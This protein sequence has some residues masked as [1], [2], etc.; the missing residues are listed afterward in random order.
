MLMGNEQIPVTPVTAP[1]P[2]AS[3][4]ADAA[5][6]KTRLRRTASRF[7]TVSLRSSCPPTQRL[8]SRLLSF[9]RQE[10]G[11]WLASREPTPGLEPGTPSLREK[12]GG[13]AG[14]PPAWQELARG[15]G[16]RAVR[17]LGHGLAPGTGLRTC[18]H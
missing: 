9:T 1:A 4:T 3:A 7:T 10:R 15:A 13:L 14:G 11:C 5:S 2:G 16:S 18:G 12:S 6:P 8:S 17:S